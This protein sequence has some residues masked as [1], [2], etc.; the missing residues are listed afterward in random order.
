VA[1]PG[2]AH[3]LASFFAWTAWTAAANR[4][5]KTYSYTANWPPE[6]LAGTTLTADALVWSAVSIITLLGGMGI[7][8][9]FFGRFDW[10]GWRKEQP[11]VRFVP[12][13][14]VALAP[15]QRAIVWFLLVASALFLLQT[16]L[17][18]LIAHYRAEPE[19]F[20]GIDL[21][22][23]LPYNAART[24]HL[25]LALFWVSTSF[26]ATGIFIAP[27]VAGREPRGQGR[28]TLALFAALVLVVLG[29]LAGEYLSIRGWLRQ[30]WWWLGHQGWEYLDLGRLWQ[31]LLVVGLFLWV[32]ILWRGLRGRLRTEGFGNMPWL[33]FFA[34]LAIPTFYAVGLLA[35]PRKAFVI[36]DFWRFWV[37]HLWVEDFLEL[38][39]TV[40]V[41]YVFVLLGTVREQTALRVIYLD[42]VLYSV[43]GVVGTMHH[44]Y[45]SGTPSAH[46]AL[47]ATFSAMEVIPLLLLTLEAWGFIRSGER[48]I[49]EF[50]HRW[51]VWFL[52]AVGV[53]NFLGAGVFGFLINLPVVSYYEI[54]TNLTANH[55]HGA[56]MGVYGM[57]AI[58]LLLF[59][60]RYLTRPDRWSDRAARLSFWS[61]N[62]GLAW[63]LFA[64]LFPVGVTQLWDALARGYW[65][66]RS[67]EFLGQT[68]VR[69]LEWLRLPGDALFI[70]GGAVPLVW[71]CVRAVRFPSAG[72]IPADAEVPS[73]L[74]TESPAAPEV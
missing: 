53:W 33:L 42:V 74:F 10:L 7:V 21:S 71:M 19:A 69:A 8:L 14:D 73:R 22:R 72:R 61:L 3:Q 46:I 65:H 26:L 40:V 28:L 55:G 11:P 4:P 51:A 60:L 56:M 43:G 52:I 27:I 44:L 12:P 38:F 35:S 1:D 16:L 15:A 29:S 32:F 24:W 2:E 17:G 59:C 31:S 47:G 45:F 67:P 64:N 9:W 49:G 58:G 23:V 13:G 41:A 70:L 34:A 36:A 20:F 68:W 25:Q 66:A 62:A 39:T 50:P 54:G 30:T 57:L 6:P 63:M 18:G 5:G 37:V 48:T